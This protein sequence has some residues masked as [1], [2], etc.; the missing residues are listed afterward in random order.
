MIPVAVITVSDSCFRGTRADLSGPAVAEELVAHGF[1]ATDLL[2]VEDEKTSIEDALRRLAAKTRLVVTT[3]GTGIGPRDVTPEA[4]CAVC[5]R[6]LD[7]V[8]EAMRAAG[9]QETKFAALSRGVCGTLGKSLILN[10]PGSPRGAVT[11]LRAVLPL[12]PHAL[13]LL[14]GETAH[15]PPPVHEPTTETTASQTGRGFA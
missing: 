1:D 3:G 10:L 7:G 5:D 14:A 4:T 9:G 12:L 15:E 6:L 8:A 13:E 11:S 2:S